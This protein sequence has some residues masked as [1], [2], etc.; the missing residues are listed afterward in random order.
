MPKNFYT[1][2][3]LPK[4]D[5]FEV[6]EAPMPS[7]ITVSSEIG[8]PRL[9]GGMGLMMARRKVIVKRLAAII[10]L[11][12]IRDHQIPGFQ[13]GDSVTQLPILLLYHTGTIRDLTRPPHRP[14]S[15]S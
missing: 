4:K 7:L 13:A 15:G 12:Q 1:L 5:G 11:A 10:W 2:L 8:L 6:L 9:P 14:A 3:I